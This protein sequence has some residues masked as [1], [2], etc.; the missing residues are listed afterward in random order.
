MP[1]TIVITGATGRLGQ[2]CTQ[3]FSQAHWRV[4]PYSV[5]AQGAPQQTLPVSADVLLHAANPI[6]TQWATQAL[7]ALQQSIDMAVRMQS[8]LMLPGNIYNYQPVPRHLDEGAAQ[9][10]TSRKGRIRIQMEEML[11]QA[12]RTQGLRCVVLRAGDFFGS[13]KGSWFDLALASKLHKGQFVY[14][15]PLDV[16]HAWAY[17]PDLA[18]VFVSL[19]QQRTQLA[20]FES[21]HFAGHT[22]TG[23]DWLEVLT[24]IAQAQG[25]LGSAEN[26]RTKSLPWPLMKA[27]SP[28]IPLWRELLEMRYLWQEPHALVGD[29]LQ[30][31]IG[32]LAHTALLPAVHA[33]LQ[34]LDM[35]PRKQP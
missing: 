19:A 35:V 31:R 29:R 8:L 28:V 30:Q 20:A 10:A 4:L 23:Q 17:L 6:Y 27:L 3:A 13:G 1:S 18:Q 21:L 34:A 12:T 9:T 11:H 33:A 7:P 16:P 22:L 24:P 26:L 2:A 15:G 25:W 5:Q 14:P 32:N